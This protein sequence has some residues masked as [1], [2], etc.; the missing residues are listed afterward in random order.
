MKNYIKLFGIIAFVAVIGFSFISCEEEEEITIE[1][2]VGRLTITNIPANVYYIIATANVG[3]TDLIAGK[4]ITGTTE[5]SVVYADVSGTGASRQA[6]MNVWKVSSDLMK[7]T[8][9]NG[10]DTSVTVKV[11]YK[12]TSG[13]D[14]GTKTVTGV[15]FASGIGTKAID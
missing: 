14:A 10:N 9:Y 8:N 7:Y 12:N 13:D 15:N 4:K 11:F 5:A 1:D 2:T 3:G 6:V